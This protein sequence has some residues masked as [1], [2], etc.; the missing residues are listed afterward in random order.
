MLISE[1]LQSQGQAELKNRTRKSFILSVGFQLAQVVEGYVVYDERGI[2]SINRPVELLRMMLN[3]AVDEKLLR[4]D[5]NP[6]TEKKSKSLVD[7]QAETKR[8]RIPNF[9]EEMAARNLH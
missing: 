7:R 1:G 6:F 8:Q 2:E 5:Q 9:G 4:R 3:Y